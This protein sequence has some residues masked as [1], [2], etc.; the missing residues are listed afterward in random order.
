MRCRRRVFNGGL[1]GGEEEE[2]GE[3]GMDIEG[4]AGGS[5]DGDADAVVEVEFRRS[6]DVGI[7]RRRVGSWEVRVRRQDG[8][9]I[10]D[11]T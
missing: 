8:Q 2:E 3:E 11:D 1:E 6:C 7:R 5:G 9:I 10:L 4:E